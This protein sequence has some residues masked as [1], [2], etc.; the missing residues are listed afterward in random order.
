LIFEILL[1]R[2]KVL[3]SGGKVA[4]LRI[5]GQL[6]EGSGD[7]TVVLRCRGRTLRPEIFSSWQNPTAPQID[8]WTAGPDQVAELLLELLKSGLNALWGVE[9][10]AGDGRN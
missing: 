2:L 4:G 8:S 10:A 7:G 6:V 1:D 5:L 3:L 9:N